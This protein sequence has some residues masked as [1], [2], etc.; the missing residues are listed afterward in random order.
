[1][2]SG[3]LKAISMTSEDLRPTSGTRPAKS[4]KKYGV[5]PNKQC[6]FPKPCENLRADHS[7]YMELL[8]EL[9]EIPGGEKSLYP[10]RHPFWIIC[11]Q[12]RMTGFGRTLPLPCFRPVKGAPEHISDNVLRLMGK[13]KTAYTASL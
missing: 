9:R 5:C 8:K 1:M 11:W 7:D 12:I 10:L 3:F 6:L 2:G 4:R 13:P